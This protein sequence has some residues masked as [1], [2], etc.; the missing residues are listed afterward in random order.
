MSRFGTYYVRRDIP[1]AASTR[2]AATPGALS[3]DGTFDDAKGFKLPRRRISVRSLIE[4][5]KAGLM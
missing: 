4:D 3:P 1:R 5:S 2:S